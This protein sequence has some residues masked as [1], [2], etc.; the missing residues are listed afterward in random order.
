MKNIIYTVAM[1]DGGTPYHLWMAMLLIS[2]IR[3]SG[4]DGHVMLFTDAVEEPFLASR[5]D[6]EQ[7][8][9][10]LTAEQKAAHAAFRVKY[11]IAD[12]LPS[13]ADWLMY[14]DTD[15]L[16]AKDPT[17]ALRG[18]AEVI[19]AEEPW[20]RVTGGQNNGY[21]TDEEMKTSTQVAINSGVYAHR[22]RCYREFVKR[23]KQHDQTTPLRKCFAFDQSAFVRTILDWEGK[24]QPFREPFSVIYPE[25]QDVRLSG[26]Q[27][28]GL[29]HF[30]GVRAPEKLR[31]MIGFYMM[32][33]GESAMPFIAELLKG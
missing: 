16:V 31:R 5:K 29:L 1:D 27:R 6:V 22:G 10:E 25:F 7:I 13:D 4:F 17:L 15:C 3:R 30:N 26:L 20:D 9:V 11:L 18:D 12:M 33:Y 32:Q 23:W 24:V 21:L 8:R 19:F 28:A 14:I 2:S